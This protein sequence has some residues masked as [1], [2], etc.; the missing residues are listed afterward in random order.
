MNNTKKIEESLKSC[1]ASI[2]SGIPSAVPFEDIDIDDLVDN[3]IDLSQK[4][5]FKFQK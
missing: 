1:E 3:L 2:K 5:D 4:L